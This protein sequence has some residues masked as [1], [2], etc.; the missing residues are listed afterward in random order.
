MIKYCSIKNMRLI[1]IIPIF[2]LTLISSCSEP[3]SNQP[4]LIPCGGGI[5][6]TC[7]INMFCKYDSECGGIDKKGYCART[8]QDCP[9]DENPVCGCDNK[10]Y[11]NECIAE[12]LGVTVKNMGECLSPPTFLDSQ[13]E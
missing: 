2:F 11:L 6:F 9:V 4:P 8:P 12:T 7:P 13:N 3:S 1:K 10:E 5:L